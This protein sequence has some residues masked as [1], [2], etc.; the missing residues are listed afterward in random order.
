MI[1]NDPTEAFQKAIT[2]GRLNEELN[3]AFYAGDWM[4]MFTDKHGIDMFKNKAT[5][6]YLREGEYLNGLSR[7]L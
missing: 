6:R 4:Y 3:S 7:N 5:R 1:H 2:E